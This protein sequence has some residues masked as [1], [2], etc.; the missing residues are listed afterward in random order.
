QRLVAHG[1]PIAD[2]PRLRWELHDPALSDLDTP[3][4]KM[5][6]DVILGSSVI[7]ADGLTRID[8]IEVPGRAAFLVIDHRGRGGED[9]PP[10]IVP[11]RMRPGYAVRAQHRALHVAVPTCQATAAGTI[12]I[13]AG[14]FQSGGVGDPPSS[15]VTQTG[16]PADAETKDLPRY[17]IDRT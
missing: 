6:S 17:S 15:Y 14:P 16:W 4:E 1:V 3:G 10:P 13:P 11:T 2:L 8:A 12:E 7:S 9:C 5:R